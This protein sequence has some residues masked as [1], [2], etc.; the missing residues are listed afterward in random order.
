MQQ[1]GWFSQ[2]WNLFGP[3]LLE[4]AVSIAVSMAANSVLLIKNIDAYMAALGSGS[5]E[6]LSEFISKQLDELL[7]YSGQ[8]TIA[9]AI[10]TIPVMIFLMWR[11]GKKRRRAGIVKEPSAPWMKFLAV[12]PFAA[13]V[14]I[15]LNNILILSN[16]SAVSESYSQTAS[17]QY[18]IPFALQ[19]IGFGLITPL[20]EELMF[21]GVIYRRL[22]MGQMPYKRAMILS[23][24]MFGLYHGNLVQFIYAFILGILFVYLYEKYHSLAAPVLAHVFVNLASVILTKVDVFTWMFQEPVRMGVITVLCAAVG[25]GMFVLISQMLPHP[26]TPPQAPNQGQPL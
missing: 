21:R 17:T 19:L 22:R 5:Q 24:L 25:S 7:T 4:G 11:D 20:C 18:S 15:G 2:L 14:G 3:L 12:I 1:K 23:A 6:A 9:T 8:I 13:A 10:C 26:E 16:L